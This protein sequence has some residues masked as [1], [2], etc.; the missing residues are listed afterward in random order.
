VQKNMHIITSHTVNQTARKNCHYSQKVATKNSFKKF[1]HHLIVSQISTVISVLYAA[2][3]IPWV[4][5]IRYLGIHFVRAKY[6]KCPLDDVRYIGQ[7]TVSGRMG[8]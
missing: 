4:D 6:F 5:T 2:L 3:I 1:R 8:E 7:A